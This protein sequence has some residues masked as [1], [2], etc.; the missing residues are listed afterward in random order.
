LSFQPKV[1]NPDGSTSTVHS[2]SYALD[3]GEVLLPSVTPDGRHLGLD[4]DII[5]EY[6]KTGRH[7]G[8]FRTPE[9]ATNYAIGLHNRYAKGDFERR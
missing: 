1:R 8:K 7:L 5:N 4:D 2:S 6:Q 9:A 3:G